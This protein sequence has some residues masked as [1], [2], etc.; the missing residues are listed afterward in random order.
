MTASIGGSET[1]ALSKAGSLV[2]S[3]R[4]DYGNDEEIPFGWAISS[5]MAND[6]RS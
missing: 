4:I 5:T 6:N 2:S 1:T 3:I